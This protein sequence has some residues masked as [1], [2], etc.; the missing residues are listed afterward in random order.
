MLVLTR[1]K[2][3]ELSHQHEQLNTSAI[4]REEKALILCYL[5]DFYSYKD[6]F[7]SGGTVEW[8]EKHSFVFPF[9]ETS[10]VM[11]NMLAMQ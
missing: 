6:Y 3:H 2:S 5:R 7:M 9:R 11:S 8:Q 1:D 10:L 4:G